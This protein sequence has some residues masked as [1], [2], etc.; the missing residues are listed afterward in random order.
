NISI[1]SS[2]LVRV[3][4]DMAAFAQPV[5]TDGF[6]ALFV[7]SD[8]TLAN[9]QSLLEENVRAW[10]L[11]TTKGQ[12]P[13]DQAA[14][15]QDVTHNFV[16]VA[17]ALDRCWF[18]VQRYI[19]M[20]QTTTLITNFSGT[21]NTLFAAAHGMPLN[22][23]VMVSFTTSGA[24]PGT[25]PALSTTTYYFAVALDANNFS[26]YSTLADATAAT[27]VITIQSMGGN[28]DVLYWKNAPYIYLEELDFDVYT[29]CTFTYTFNAPT[30]N[31]TG[32]DSLNGQVVQMIGDG[33][34]LNNQT[35]LN[36]QISLSSAVS[37][38]KVG[39]QFI[40]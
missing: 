14:N 22:T 12:T 7:N 1:T 33:Y 19:P 32:L 27:N 11:M 18:L 24:L 40:P 28:S 16:H 17:T 21:N 6:Y 36:G 31:V 38:L 37:S 25:T 26:I 15:G 13:I 29:D 34:V 20:V 4:V 35:V 9:F 10:S 23:P 3:P 8:G 2:G 39:L 5:A 30:T